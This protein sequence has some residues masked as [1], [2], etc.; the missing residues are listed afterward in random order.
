L[1]KRSWHVYIL[2]CSDGSL[3]T[4]I[5]T[6]IGERLKTHNA[7]NGAKYIRGRRPVALV[8]REHRANRSSAQKREAEIKKL[9]KQNKERLILH[10][11][12]F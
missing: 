5:T 4:G 3:Y 11:G 12:G 10:K 7:G 1:K 9:G 8:Y 6:E 2:R